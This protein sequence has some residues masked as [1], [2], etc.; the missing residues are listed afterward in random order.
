MTILALKIYY[1]EEEAN[2]EFEYLREGLLHLGYDGDFVAS[3]IRLA[4]T[5][6]N[7]WV[8]ENAIRKGGEGQ[9]SLEEIG[10]RAIEIRN[11]NRKRIQYKN[12]ITKMD[13]L[14]F[15]EVKSQHLSQ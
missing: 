13:N 12:A 10:K 14:G 7:I 1:G 8:L 11:L 9:F 15:Q 4:H 6:H 2:K 3:V 5:N